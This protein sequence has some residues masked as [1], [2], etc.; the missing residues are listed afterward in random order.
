[1]GGQS[2]VG[3]FSRHCIRIYALF[4][5]KKIILFC[6]AQ[7]LLSLIDCNRSIEMMVQFYDFEHP[8]LV[9]QF[10][11]YHQPH[12]ATKQDVLVKTMP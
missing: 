7:K 10:L 6:I 9:V 12:S 4:F 1:M 11:R 2:I 8:V 3:P 5:H